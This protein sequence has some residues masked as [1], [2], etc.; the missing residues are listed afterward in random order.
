M[1]AAGRP[2]VYRWPD[3][4]WRRAREESMAMPM[5]NTAESADAEALAV[6]ALGYI[7]A[8]PVLLPRFLSITG[9]EASQIRRVAGEPGFM[10][11]VL[12]FI[13]AHEPTLIAF[14]E[15][16]DVAPARV[17]K[18]LNALP[19]GEMSYDIQP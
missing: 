2:F 9:I 10:A 4:E 13:C 6:Q 11:G 7:A 3:P 14:A 1:V 8:D 15:T 16:A 19:G 12:Q 18:A 5:T 17:Q